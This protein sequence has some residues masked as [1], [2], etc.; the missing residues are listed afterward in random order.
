MKFDSAAVRAAGKWALVAV[1]AGGLVPL[2]GPAPA[3]AAPVC[4][5]EVPPS[6]LQDGCDD[7]NPPETSLT[8]S[9]TPNAAGLVTASTV[10]FTLG[11][12]VDDGDLGPFGFECRLSGAP[13]S[14]D[15]QA[16]P[17]V[18]TLAG[19]ASALRACE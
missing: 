7:A 11:W 17:A 15:W 10:T 1:V 8:S 6:V 19:P 18:V 16:C 4:T 2:T 9:L 3:Q 13:T 5:S 14:Y 12:S